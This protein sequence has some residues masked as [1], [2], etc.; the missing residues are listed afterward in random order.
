MFGFDDSPKPPTQ[1][2]GRAFPSPQQSPSNIAVNLNARG[3]QNVGKKLDTV[4]GQGGVSAT[5]ASATK[6]ASAGTKPFDF[7]SP[8]PDD[9]VLQTQGQAFQKRKGLSL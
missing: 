5:L 4:Q 3:K 1:R 7:S 8:S 6:A 2:N 9:I